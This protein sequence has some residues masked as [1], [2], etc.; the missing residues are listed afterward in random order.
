MKKTRIII[1]YVAGPVFVPSAPIPHHQQQET[2]PNSLR[3]ILGKPEKKMA[4]LS[5]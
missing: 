1:N 5:L 3:P 4:T 2:L